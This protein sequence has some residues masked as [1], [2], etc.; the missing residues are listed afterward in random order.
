MTDPT[1][2]P[3]ETADQAPPLRLLF[4]ESTTR[5]NL[6][7]IHCRRMD[8][9]EEAAKEDLTTEEVR[10]LIDS[11]ATLGRSIFVF[12]GGEPLMRPDWRELAAH[13]RDKG[14]ITALA[15]NGTLIDEALAADIADV[16]FHRVS[17]SLDGANAET[18]DTFRALPGAF[19]N[20]KR[21]AQLLRAH[22]V[23]LQI[24]ATIAAH[25]DR[26]LED[27]LALAR[28]LDAEALHL[29]LLVPVGCGVQIGPSHQLDPER[30]E[31]VLRW[32]VEKQKSGTGIE[33]KATCAP[34][35][36]RIAIQEGLKVR[37][38]GCLCGVAVAFVSHRG[39]VF[40]C[41]YLPVSCGNVRETDFAEIWKG[42]TVFANL[43]DYEALEGKCGLCRF[44]GACGGCRARA[45]A[46][47]GDYL[48]AEPA[49]TYR[50]QS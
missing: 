14:L 24:N 8:V 40:P 33:L 6:A 17:I 43:R 18:H 25:N 27:L 32:V 35:Y 13:A 45:F 48:S 34:H 31:Q 10:G 49:C 1:K 16:G 4:W 7:C 12:S 5:C 30:Y 39:E 44:K 28:D 3:A 22:D 50:P 47:T 26:Q 21:G 46:Q 41:G 15:T 37:G 9:A 36:N 38:R 29:F 2:A 19:D 23:A 20:A 42:S 11:V